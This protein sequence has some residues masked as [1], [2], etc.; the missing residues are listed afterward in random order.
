MR[1]TV[2]LANDA[3]WQAL[4]ARIKLARHVDAAIAY[5]GRGGAKLLPLRRGDRLVVDMSPGT[6]RA[7][8]TDPHE[9]ESLVQ[10][11][12]RVF[13]RKNLHAKVVLADSAVIAGSA[14]VSTNS[15]RFLDEAAILTEAP[16]V[17]RRAKEFIDRLC[18]EPVRPEY[19][20][21]CKRIYRPPKFHFAGN[22]RPV[23][24]GP[25]RVRHAK[26]WLVS[27][28]EGSIPDDEV[29]RYEKSERKAAKLVKDKKRFETDSF[30]WPRKTKMA[31]E[32]EMGDWIIRCLRQEDGTVRVY[33]PGQFLLLDSYVRDRRTGK[34]RFVYHLEVPARG[35]SYTWGQFTQKAKTGLNPKQ[36][37]KPR[38]TAVRDPLIADALLG[39]WTETGYIARR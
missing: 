28:V 31:D 24:K 22:G 26:L 30:W 19:L 16:A 3:L 12:V 7:G 9:I 4:P 35:Q 21:K 32:L 27:L 34:M 10:R 33:P 13:T 17:V 20:K 2:F 29:E 8:G 15:F 39:L 25:E 11:G 14:N 37:K 5:L 18:T 36:R 6:V 1:A 38:T 23:T